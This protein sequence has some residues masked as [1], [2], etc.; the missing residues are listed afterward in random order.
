MI[1]LKAKANFFI[2]KIYIHLNSNMIILKVCEYAKNDIQ[3]YNLNSNMIILKEGILRFPFL[4]FLHLNS[5]MIILKA[6]YTNS[7]VLATQT[8]KFQYDNT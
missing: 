3:K 7:L 5:N 6:E 8:F 4:S 2:K 1:I